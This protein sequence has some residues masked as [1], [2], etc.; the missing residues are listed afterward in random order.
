MKK[1]LVFIILSLGLTAGQHESSTGA[2]TP[3]E[4]MLE[5]SMGLLLSPLFI[6]PGS[7]EMSADSSKTLN[8][9]A[10]FEKLTDQENVKAK[11]IFTIEQREYLALK[12]ED[13][14]IFDKT[15]MG[16]PSK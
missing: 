16:T 4:Y 3:E 13:E 14:I 15:T 11:D 7:I 1:L 6:I 9:Y 5:I 2:I 8:N 12:D 10:Q